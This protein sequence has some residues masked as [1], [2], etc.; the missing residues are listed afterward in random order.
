[1]LF[2]QLTPEVGKFGQLSPKAFGLLGNFAT[3]FGERSFLQ[4]TAS[5]SNLDLEQIE[6]SVRSKIRFQQTIG[7]LQ[8]SYLLNVEYNYRERL[9]NGSLG[10]Q[11]VNSSFGAIL[12]SPVI[13]IPNTDIRLSYQASVQNVNAPTDS[14]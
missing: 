8:E 2:P 6:N 5:F 10:F 7:Q 12:T 1:M 14:Q 3:N 13:V 11:T 9:F 4:A